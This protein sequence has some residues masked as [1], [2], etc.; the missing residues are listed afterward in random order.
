MNKKATKI[1]NSEKR[2]MAINSINNY[3]SQLQQHYD[4]SNHELSD[5][6]NSIKSNYKFRTFMDIWKCIFRF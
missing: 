3:L 1:Y 4:L 5:I 6:I 2:N